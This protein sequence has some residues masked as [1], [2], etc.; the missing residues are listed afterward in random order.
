MT[1]TLVVEAGGGQGRSR[2]SEPAT[3]SQRGGDHENSQHRTTA[4]GRENTGGSS[5]GY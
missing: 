4:P 5:N 3:G 1:G 2:S